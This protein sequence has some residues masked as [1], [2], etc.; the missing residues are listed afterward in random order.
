[1]SRRRGCGPFGGML[2]GYLK[3][4]MSA[5]TYYNMTKLALKP[6]YVMEGNSLN[7]SW[8]KLILKWL[9]MSLNLLLVKN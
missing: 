8:L 7:K 1:V 4:D 5:V 2:V 3:L 9:M 6:V